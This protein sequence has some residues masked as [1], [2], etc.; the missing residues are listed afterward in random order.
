ML[1]VGI[2]TWYYGA[3]YGAKAQAYA[4]QQIVNGLGY[5]AIMIN[6]RTP[7]YNK[8]NILTNLNFKNKKRHPL[9][10]LKGLIRTLKFS[11]AN[12]LFKE[13]KRVRNAFEIDSLGLDCI[14]FGSDAI[15]NIKH[16]LFSDMY[17]GVGICDTSKITYSPS[18]EYLDPNT[19]LSSEC[20][21]SLK[22]MKALSVRDE[23]TQRLIKNNIGKEA[24]IT[25][26][27]TIMYDF[28]DVDCECVLPENFILIYTFSDWR[29]YEKSL[30]MFAEEKSCKIVAVGRTCGWADFS[31]DGASFRLWVTLFRKAQ[32]IFTDSFRGTV[33]ALKNCKEIILCA[34]PDKQDKIRS[35]L[36]DAGVSRTFYDGSIDISKYM[37]E[38]IDYE[39]VGEKM[40]KL[41]QDSLNYL[42]E[43]LTLMEGHKI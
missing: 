39:V 11:Y 20:I 25:S 8:T 40:G 36:K 22:A 5:E 16:W 34:R 31:I 3:N 33:F 35:L 37:N 1:K 13:S 4:L 41:K 10:V 32:F 24:I 23:N 43:S 19:E 12:S 28:E 17:Y 9:L 6:Y 7:K 38:P 42:K 2:L 14:I 15:F 26:D 18:C 27:P 30:K 29:V 21:Q